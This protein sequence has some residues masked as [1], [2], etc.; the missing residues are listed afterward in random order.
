MQRPVDRPA[1]LAANAGRFSGFADL[2]D[3]VR[4]APPPALAQ[5][6]VAYCG[7]PAP[8]VVDLGSGTG[9]STRWEST[10]ASS[11][12]GVEPSA[13][14]RAIAEGRAAPHTRFVAGFGH[15]TGL[16]D[17]VADVVVA[18]QSLH[19]MEPEGTLAEVA[20]LLRPGGV[21]A[22]VDCDWPPTVGSAAAESAWEECRRLQASHEARLVGEE[23]AGTPPDG[24]PPP[25][26]GEGEASGPASHPGQA[27]LG[28]VRRWP[29]DSHLDRIRASGHFAWCRELALHR[30][31]QGDARRFLELLRSQ[32]DYQALR[33]AGLD[34]DALGVSRLRAVV[35]AAL[36]EEPS[37]WWF[38]YRV[39]LGVVAGAPTR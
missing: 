26:P 9:L 32:G 22:A 21:F 23:H 5:V 3:R 7:T 31:E 34:D 19:W 13:D 37:P 10:W 38:T 18:V 20:R 8:A 30:Q 6:L 33:R 15:R 12:V 16:G 24:P 39:R 35:T 28:G 36:G 2:Y 27:L 29:K 25:A 4:P 14:M 1:D 11:V 17:G